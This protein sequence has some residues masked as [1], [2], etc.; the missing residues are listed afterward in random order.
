MEDTSQGM[1]DTEHL[2]LLL[3]N[4]SQVISADSKEPLRIELCVPTQADGKLRSRFVVQLKRS[5]DDKWICKKIDMHQERFEVPYQG[6]VDLA[7]CGGGMA[8]FGQTAKLDESKLSG[9][10]KAVPGASV[11]AL[12]GAKAL[13]ASNSAVD[14]YTNSSGGAILLPCEAWI[15]VESGCASD[16][17]IEA[18]VVTGETSRSVASCHYKEGQLS[19]VALGT[20]EKA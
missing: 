14:R 6:G 5:D 10:W 20:E 2:F 19:W 1:E 3:E 9:I 15:R 12:D 16:L 8:G 18:G 13:T 17:E 11:Y 4:M 7:G